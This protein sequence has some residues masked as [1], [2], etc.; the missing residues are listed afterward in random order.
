[1]V[2]KQRIVES[3]SAAA[4]AYNEHAHMQKW[5]AKQVCK[6]VRQYIPIG[7]KLLDLGCGTGLISSQLSQQ[8]QLSQLDISSKM[9]DVAKQFAP[10][11]SGSFDDIPQDIDFQH[12][13]S[14]MALQWS[15]DINSTFNHIYQ[16]LNL[17]SLCIFSILYQKAIYSNQYVKKFNKLDEIFGALNQFAILHSETAIYREE[18][19]S[20]L[21]MLKHLRKIGAGNGGKLS[22]S[23]RH[24]LAKPCIMKWDVAFFVA[25][26]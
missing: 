17:N 1:M 20:G 14:S 8:Y 10:I 9:L 15:N 22:L 12:V 4:S 3:F 7:E 11:Y 16:R 5:A 23:D 6:L 26:K 13:C 2:D 25:Q 19:A 21:E 18:Y 24:Q